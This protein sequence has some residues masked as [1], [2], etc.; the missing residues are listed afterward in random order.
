MDG[1]GERARRARRD[2]IKGDSAEGDSD[3]DSDS[4]D[5]GGS[6]RRKRRREASEPDLSKPVR[7][8][9]T[10]YAVRSHEPEPVPVNAAGKE[11]EAGAE[12]EDIEPLPAMFGKIREGARARREEKERERDAVRR[13]LRGAC[14]LTPRWPI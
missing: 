1:G 5:D 12:A 10:G 13:R 2:A 14:S 3:S 8:V 6:R 9:S 4:D 11:D 7:F